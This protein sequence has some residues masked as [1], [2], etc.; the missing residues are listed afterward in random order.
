[1]GGN[2]MK[3]FGLGLFAIVLILMTVHG[4]TASEWF[5]PIMNSSN[6]PSPYVAYFGDATTYSY[7]SGSVA[8]DYYP[9]DGSTDTYVGI[10][11]TGSF[12]ARGLDFGTD[13]I[14]NGVRMYFNTTDGYPTSFDLQYSDNPGLY[15]WGSVF[16]GQGI[17][18]TEDGW[19]EY[20]FTS[21]THRYFRLVLYGANGD[22]LQVVPEIEFRL[23]AMPVSDCQDL[24]IVGRKYILTQNITMTGGGACSSYCFKMFENTTLDC[25]GYSVTVPAMCGANPIISSSPGVTIQ[26]CTIIAET[27]TAGPRIV[28]SAGAS[29]VNIFGNTL[30]RGTAGMD[31]D[32]SI[33]SGV[34]GVNISGNKFKGADGQSSISISE[35]GAYFENNQ[36][37]NTP[38]LDL[39]STAHTW[40]N[41][42]FG[43]CV[44]ADMNGVCDSAYTIDGSNEDAT[45][46]S[47]YA[48]CTEENQCVIPMTTC[49]DINLSGPYVTYV[50]QNNISAVDCVEN[51]NGVMQIDASD[52]TLDCQGYT[53]LADTSNDAIFVNYLG[54][55]SSNLTIK[56][57]IFE[58]SGDYWG[59]MN[60]KD[61]S[62]FL[63]QNSTLGGG[64]RQA[65][66]Y[67]RTSTGSIVDS[68]ITSGLSADIEAGVTW[69]NITRY[70]TSC[71]GY[72]GENTVL[73][74]QNSIDVT[75]V[76]LIKVRGG[77]YDAC[78]FVNNP[79]NVTVDCQGNEIYG[80][81]TA[82]SDSYAAVS[83]AS[84]VVD[85]TMTVKNCIISGPGSSTPYVRSIV[86]HTAEVGDLG[87]FIV[88]NNTVRDM[89]AT[90]YFNGLLVWDNGNP[91]GTGIVR[92]NRFINIT[93]G[94]S[95]SQMLEFEGNNDVQ[96]YGNVFDGCVNTCSAIRINTPQNAVVYDNVISNYDGFGLGSAASACG[97]EC[98]FYNNSI[99][100]SGSYVSFVGVVN[101]NSSTIGNIYLRPNGGGFSQLCA[102]ANSDGIC[103]LTYDPDNAGYT[104]YLPQALNIGQSNEVNIT[105]CGDY[106]GY[107]NV[108]VRLQ[109]SID[110]TGLSLVEDTNGGLD[111]CIFFGEAKNVTL[112]CQ[113]NE[114]Y[115]QDTTGTLGIYNAISFASSIV[116]QTMVVK[117][118]IISGSSAVSNYITPISIHTTATGDLGSF[119]VENNTIRNIAAPDWSGSVTSLEVR[120]NG[121]LGGTGIV[122]NNHFNNLTA[123]NIAIGIYL[124]G[125]N[126]L[127]VY[128]NELNGC[129]GDCRAIQV[130]SM[131][132]SV[133]IYNNNIVNYESAFG[134]IQF[135][136]NVCGV[137]CTLYNNSINASGTYFSFTGIVNLNSSTIGNAWLRPNGA[138]FSQTCTDANDDDICDTPYDVD[139]SGN[140]DY[141][142]IVYGDRLVEQCYPNIT[143]PADLATVHGPQVTFTVGG[144]DEFLYNVTVDGIQ[145]LQDQ[146]VSTFDVNLSAG[147][148]TIGIVSGSGNVTVQVVNVEIS[149]QTCA[150]LT[151]PNEENLPSISGIPVNFSVYDGYEF[152]SPV[153]N[154]S[155]RY[156]SVIANG[157]C[158]YTV[159]NATNRDYTCTV[160]M[161]YYYG[162]GSYDMVVKYADGG[163]IVNLSTV[164]AC[165]YGQLIASRKD[166]GIVTFPGAA[167][168]VANVSSSVPV[169]MYNTGNVQLALS[170]TGYDLVGQISPGNKLLASSFK[171]GTTL[172]T[173]VNMSNGVEVSLGESLVPGNGSRVDTWLWLSMPSTM[174]P[175]NYVVTTPWQIIATG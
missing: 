51:G 40:A 37:F 169:R 143:D 68:T 96:V 136:Y 58:G 64:L 28:F 41:N 133:V 118:C 127:Q 4:A 107:E 130:F 82:P 89:S 7:Q 166:V 22:L 24:D 100:T 11:E 31:G 10:N 137:G 151:Y 120:D 112:D 106:T 42:Y 103:D 149:G 59:S 69:S 84:S 27:H 91:G 29:N 155:L 50:L 17:T 65:F 129:V 23:I 88:E 138:G 12:S 48:A 83:F 152:V 94:S 1:M 113:G 131:P 45:P 16:N 142:P 62:N 173:A 90:G 116:D 70:V 71:G 93:G 61:V 5:S 110:V 55:P 153:L 76:S 161:Q 114:I 35:S 26:N 154:V 170:M 121:N 108:I 150:A 123:G 85:Q 15:G 122:R 171:A 52:V 174:F 168:G 87:N 167:A 160:P 172:Q 60:I 34:T 78:I 9:F 126:D 46:Q 38:N 99:N 124:S 74:L 163:E 47:Q 43:V 3:Q 145:V 117:N 63:I 97:T 132:Q 6:T 33:A 119:I 101:L 140:M 175:Q 95:A 109:N 8:W 159:V 146:A 144:C 72:S 19:V 86:V 115:G 39:I 105:T 21:S 66:L 18:V 148:R 158:T 92:N 135:N 111:S 73:R 25:E 13:V 49:T 80:V 30:I 139:G 54:S 36:F 164:G 102:D 125:Y 157:T 56:N 44:D 75:G 81:E 156:G 53:I 14:L 165:E 162:N 134:M 77:E 32:I 147:N 128:D 104:D 79:V 2:A 57:C 67:V 98:T 141:L 20:N